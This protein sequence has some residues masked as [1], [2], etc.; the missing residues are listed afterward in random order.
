M[1]DDR[2]SDHRTS[3]TAGAA[4]PVIGGVV[5]GAEVQVSGYANAWTF[6]RGQ[7][8]VSPRLRLVMAR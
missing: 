3:V 7:V 2:G 5:L 4:V 1:A 8:T 6:G